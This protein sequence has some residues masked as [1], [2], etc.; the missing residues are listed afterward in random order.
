MAGT[1]PVFLGG[2]SLLAIIKVHE[3]KVRK[4]LP[5]GERW[6]WGVQILRGLLKIFP[7]E[8]SLVR[9]PVQADGVLVHLGRVDLV[10]DVL[11]QAVHLPPGLE[12]DQLSTLS[13]ADQAPLLPV[14]QGC[15]S[16]VVDFIFVGCSCIQF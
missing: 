12:G 3:V 16:R 6:G 13:H 15:V 9:P 4:T 11:D 1:T 8:H 10:V 14:A 7:F 2:E 5:V